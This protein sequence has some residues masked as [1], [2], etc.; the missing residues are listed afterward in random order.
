MTFFFLLFIT[1]LVAIAIFENEKIG[2]LFFTYFVKEN[3]FSENL[4]R[5]ALINKRVK[6]AKKNHDKYIVSNYIK[7]GNKKYCGKNKNDLLYD[8]MPCRREWVQLGYE[9]VCEIDGK[10]VPIDSVK[11]NKKRLERTILRDEKK[12]LVPQYLQRQKSFIREIRTSFFNNSLTI[13]S[14]T[15]I[16]VLKKKPKPDQ[17]KG[18]ARPLCIFDLNSNLILQETNRFLT[19]KFD[20]LFENCSFAFRGKG[21]NQRIP[22]HH[23]TIAKLLEYRDK[24]SSEEIYVTECDLQKFFD[25][26]NHDIIEKK[27]NCLLNNRRIK[28]SRFSKK[29]IKTIFEQY[30]N[31][32]DFQTSVY[33]FNKDETY[34]KKNR[35]ENC[36]FKWIDIDGLKRIYGDDFSNCKIG[37]PQGGALSGFIA[38]LVLDEI[39]KAIKNL[40]DPDLLYLR[41]CD[42]MIMLHTNKDKLNAALQTYLSIAKKN[43]LFVHD[44][45]KIERYDKSFYGT[46]SKLPYKWGAPSNNTTNV[47][48]VPWISF[49]GY[50]IGFNG[51]VR[52]RFDSV[53]KEMSKQNRIVGNAVKQIKKA[54]EDG[55]DFN[56]NSIIKSVIH[57]LQGMSV[58][59]VKLYS[60]NKAPTL[61]WANGFKML[62]ANVFSFRQMRSL[63]RNRC[64]EIHILCSE[65]KK[66]ENNTI[67]ETDVTGEGSEI[68]N[69][70]IFSG[71]PF[72]YY[73]WL[74][75]KG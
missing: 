27:F 28:V 33:S 38:N 49:V 10:K 73:N 12:E 21:E 13:S 75:K 18:E 5:K 24:H 67:D 26:I 50:Q 55:F 43:K 61:C 59:H 16:P 8:I 7:N 51:E 66:F 42:D 52:V 68:P 47:T 37:V 35:C 60:E 19:K 15:I 53:K 46:K 54:N 34:F 6:L 31:C 39:D 20:S 4:I 63:D 64:R 25:T 11:K 30:L 57:R 14:P 29:R 32:Y 41:Y 1:V 70:I 71:K 44:P 74:Q 9:R 40:N 17:G 69:E 23:D 22:S 58:G 3:F 2:A 56:K 62:N 48:S 45:K 72:S 36:E 65:F